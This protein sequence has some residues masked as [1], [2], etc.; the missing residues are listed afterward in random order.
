MKYP[1]IPLL[2][3]FLLS[4][5]AIA[6]DWNCGNGHEGYAGLSVETAPIELPVAVAAVPEAP[7]APELTEGKILLA[8][9]APCNP[10]VTVCE[11]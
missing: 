7:T 9:D 5:G 6:G 3:G 10:K 1:L 11:D 2:A 4:S 8:G